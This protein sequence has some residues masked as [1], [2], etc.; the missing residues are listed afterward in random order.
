M[1]EEKQRAPENATHPKTQVINRCQ[2]LRFRVCCVFGCS[3]FVFQGG[4]KTH[5]KTQHARKHRFWERS[6]ACVFGCVAF[7]GVLW[8]LPTIRNFSIDPAWSI[9]ASIADTVFADPVSETPTN[10]P[11]IATAFSSFL[12]CQEVPSTPKCLHSKKNLARN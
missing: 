1:S 3:L 7:S 9:R 4:A 11:E 5:P 12:K 2:N 6:I 8:H 10:S